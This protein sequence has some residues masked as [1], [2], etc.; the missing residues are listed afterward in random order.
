MHSSCCWDATSWGTHN[1]S[2]SSYVMKK[3]SAVLTRGTCLVLDCDCYRARQE[4]GHAVQVN[5]LTSLPRWRSL[6]PRRIRSRVQLLTFCT[7]LPSRT[8]TGGQV[9]RRDASQV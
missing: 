5:K 8:S 2:T 9:T 4:W 1:V 3:P 7:L 6:E